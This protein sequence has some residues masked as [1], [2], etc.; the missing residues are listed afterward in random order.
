MQLG[1]GTGPVLDGLT[2]AEHALLHLLDGTRTRAQLHT[3]AARLGANPAGVDELLSLLDRLGALERPA[4]TRLDAWRRRRSRVLVG[5]PAALV[6]A[7]AA[8][9]RAAELGHVEAG[10]WALDDLE[11]ALREGTPAPARP[12]LIVL[13]GVLGVH[14][15]RADPWLRAGVPHLPVVVTDLEVTIGPLVVPPLSGAEPCLRCVEL[16]QADRDPA[17]AAILADLAEP[18]AATFVGPVAPVAL[19]AP[20]PPVAPLA[21]LASEPTAGATLAATAGLVALVAAA[22]LAGQILPRG[23]TVELTQPWPQLRH[24]RWARHPCCLVHS[25]A[26]AKTP[27]GGVTAP[28]TAPASASTRKVSPA[29]RTSGTDAG[30]G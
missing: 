10:D 15:S 27:R 17:R 13:C 25:S 22:H 2:P 7:T 24:R 14:P 3:Y 12:D 18:W 1:P 29:G 30:Q 9:L 11:L 23:I 19:L 8:A 6:D 28:A 4:D 5:G 16:H 26:H 21:P 20:V